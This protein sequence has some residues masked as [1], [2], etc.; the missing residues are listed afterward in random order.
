MPIERYADHSDGDAQTA[1]GGL[2]V[3]DES[4]VADM[5][6]SGDAATIDV[7][8]PSTSIALDWVLL[9]Y[10]LRNV[11]ANAVEHNDTE[12]PRVEVLCET[13]A[14]GLRIVVADDGPG[15]PELE[16]GAVQTGSERE[17]DHA[18]SIGF[19][20]TSWAV[21]SLGGKVIIGE[22]HLGGAEVTIEIPLADDSATT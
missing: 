17:L 15:I 6:H 14:F 18:T 22:S 12:T 21:Q 5:T 1:K 7:T 4:V 19:W 2:R 13:N 3:T 16:A 9:G 11:V 10:A 8:V 20:G